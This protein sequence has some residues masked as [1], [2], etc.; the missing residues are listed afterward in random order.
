MRVPRM[1]G[2]PPHTAGSTLILARSSSRV[3]AHTS[4]LEGHRADAIHTRIPYRAPNAMVTATAGHGLP[5][6]TLT[7]R[8]GSVSGSPAH[9]GRTPR[10]P[11]VST[12]CATAA[13]SSPGDPGQQHTVLMRRRH[14][15]HEERG[16]D[17]PSIHPFSHRLPRQAPL[18]GRLGPPANHGHRGE[19]EHANPQKRVHRLPPPSSRLPRGFSRLPPHGPEDRGEKQTVQALG[20]R[21]GQGHNSGTGDSADD[22]QGVAPGRAPS[23]TYNPHQAGVGDHEAQQPQIAVQGT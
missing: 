4:C 8:A 15:W 13:S 2:L 23:L 11:L 12:S 21:A 6:A 18:A 14:R 20:A 3:M 7:A 1:H 9:V 16:G 5:A 17:E 19:R 22:P 10:W